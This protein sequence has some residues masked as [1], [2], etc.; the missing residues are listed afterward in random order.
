L[1]NAGRVSTISAY[2]V[3]SSAVEIQGR[4]RGLG[5]ADDIFQELSRSFIAALA[6]K[7]CF[8]DGL[9]RK[10]SAESKRAGSEE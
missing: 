10:R 6:E 3:N 8:A 5:N 1:K 4:I 9:V 2:G 7:V